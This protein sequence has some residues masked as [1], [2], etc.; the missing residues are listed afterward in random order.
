MITI[1]E[2]TFKCI[3]VQRALINPIKF[4]FYLPKT[5]MMVTVPIGR[6]DWDNGTY[7]RAGITKGDWGSS[8]W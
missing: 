2:L 1:L 4:E 8:G 6:R 7:T 3:N 5:P